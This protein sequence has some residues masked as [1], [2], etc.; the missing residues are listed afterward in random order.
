M[1]ETFRTAI[2]DLMASVNTVVSTTQVT[3]GIVDPKQIGEIIDLNVF[4]EQVYNLMGAVMGTL[5]ES[6]ERI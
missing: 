5:E 4:Q 1:N 2:Y 6:M 3:S